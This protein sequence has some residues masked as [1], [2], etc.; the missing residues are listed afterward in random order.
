[1]L[2]LEAYSHADRLSVTQDCSRDDRRAQD[3]AQVPDTHSTAQAL[4]WQSRIRLDINTGSCSVGTNGKKS[5]WKMKINILNELIQIG[6][7]S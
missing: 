1:M 3:G 5:Y 2:E 7:R 4:R 6:N